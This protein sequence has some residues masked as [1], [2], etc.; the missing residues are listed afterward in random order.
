MR[1]IGVALLGLG[2]IVVGCGIKFPGT[3]G[4]GPVAPYCACFTDPTGNWRCTAPF[5]EIPVGMT[6]L[7]DV[8]LAW[9]PVLGGG[10]EQ[11]AKVLR[12]A[13]VVSCDA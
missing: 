10:N 6:A 1:K 7:V 11:I 12:R 9:A 4:E 8:A 13:K 5:V 2:L 3:S